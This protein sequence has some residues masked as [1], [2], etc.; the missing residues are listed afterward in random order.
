MNA[1]K[2]HPLALLGAYKDL[3][4]LSLPIAGSLVLDLFDSFELVR[5]KSE[6]LPRVVSLL[7]VLRLAKALALESASMKPLLGLVLVLR[8]FN[9][10][11]WNLESGLDDEPEPDLDVDLSCSVFI[12]LSGI[13]WL[14]CLSCDT[15]G[16]FKKIQNFLLFLLK[17]QH[18]NVCHQNYAAFQ[19]AKSQKSD[20][21]KSPT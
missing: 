5:E 2:H 9:E 21:S 4:K 20:F 10:P 7:L 13:A 12:L 8:T 18:E 15:L 1:S 11:E 6:S 3:G 14:L 19:N 17:L 16:I